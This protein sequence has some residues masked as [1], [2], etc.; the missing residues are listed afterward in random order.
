MGQADEVVARNRRQQVEWYGEPLG[1]RVR[2]LVERLDVSQTAFADI[3]GLSAPMLSQLMS[4]HRAKIGNPAVLSRLMAV[5]ALVTGPDFDLL[6]AREMRDRLDLI[7]EDATA[8]STTTRIP[9]TPAV[10]PPADPVLVIQA[11]LRA[12]ASAGE[13]ESAAALLDADFPDLAAILRTY[14][15][16]R[17]AEARAHLARTL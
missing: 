4:G 10:Q 1:E 6:P 17:T 7:R 13:I 16:G 8:A 9:V 11:L 12:A 3:L 5:E 2:R 14:G 15:N